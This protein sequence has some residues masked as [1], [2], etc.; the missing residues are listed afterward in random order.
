M[1]I[2]GELPDLDDLKMPSGDLEL[3]HLTS[4]DLPAPS[5]ELAPPAA[6]PVIPTEPSIKKP[7]QQAKKPAATTAARSQPK[8]SSAKQKTE[9][10][11]AGPSASGTPL[12]LNILSVAL[13]IV[14]AGVMIIFEVPI[15]AVPDLTLTTYVQGLWL[16]A[17]CFFIIAMLQDFRTALLLTGLNV[18]LLAT[19]FPTLWLLLNMPMNPMYFFVIGMIMLLAFVYTPLSVLRPKMPPVKAQVSD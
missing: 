14:I 2:D 15:N 4:L 19:V 7:Q 6:A 12:A 16:L 9:K 1:A 11:P 13:L 5:G 8:P 17:G 18:V 3:P 10:K